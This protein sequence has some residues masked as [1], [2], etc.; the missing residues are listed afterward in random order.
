MNG[1]ECLNGCFDNGIEIKS[2][3]DH[4]YTGIRKCCSEDTGT[5]IVSQKHIVPIIAFTRFNRQTA[6]ITYRWVESTVA[7]TATTA[8]IPATKPSY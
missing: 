1:Y 4:R 6:R 8:Q 2:I 5:K 3:A 7:S